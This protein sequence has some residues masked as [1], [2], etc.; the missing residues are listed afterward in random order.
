MSNL[1]PTSKPIPHAKSP[2]GEG[3]GARNCSDGEPWC[4]R[5]DR[6]YQSCYCHDQGEDV[7][8]SPLELFWTREKPTRPG[9]YWVRC[10]AGSKQI[11]EVKQ[12]AAEGEYALTPGAIEPVYGP[13]S[14][15]G[16]DWF[17]GPLYPPN[18]PSDRMADGNQGG[19]K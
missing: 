18:A 11:P 3:L 4:H 12:F 7:K 5:C 9:F 13:F 17:A 16:W 19:P 8:V 15:D 2:A 10:D 1:D 14:S 6:S